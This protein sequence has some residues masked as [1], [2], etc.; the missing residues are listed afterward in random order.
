MGS[1]PTPTRTSRRIEPDHDAMISFPIFESLHVSSYGLFPGVSK[2]Q[3]GLHIRFQPG[4]TLVLGSNG[5]G[6][7]TL[8][9]II[10][11]LLTG[12]YDITALS[13]RTDLG[14]AKLVPTKLRPKLLGT[15]AQRVADGAQDSKARLTLSLGSRLVEIE[16][17]LSNFALTQFVIDGEEQDLH[18]I[19]SYQTQIARLAGVWSFGDWLLMLHHMVFYFENR[20]DLVWDP[21][22]QRQILRFLF[23]PPATAKQWTEEERS[24]L[25]LDSD[26]RNLSATVHR[27]E[28]EL[29]DNEA[30]LESAPEIR[31]ELNTLKGLQEIDWSRRSR[32]DDELVELNEMRESARLMLMRLEHRREASFREFERAHLMA[33]EA[34]LP[35]TSDSARYILSQLMTDQDCLACGRHVP[36][37]ASSFEKRI[38]SNKC[39]VCGQPLIE[40]GETEHVTAPELADRRVEIRLAELAELDKKV[41][42]SRGERD[43][44]ETQYTSNVEELAEL[45]HDIAKRSARIDSLA[46]SLPPE[47][48]DLHAHRA[49][50][51]IM[52][53]RVE[54][55]KQRLKSKRSA[56][57]DFVKTVTATVVSHSSAI[58]TAFEDYAHGFLLESCE[59][60]WSPQKARV[61]QSGL[62]IEFPAFQLDMSGATFPS[63]VQ[64][65]DPDQVSESQREFID[66]AFRMSLMSV[67]GVTGVGSLV[68]DAPESSLDAVFVKRA[69]QVLSRFADPRGGN[70][71]VVTSN[72]TEGQLIPSLLEQCSTPKTHADRLIDLFDIAEPTAA[73]R[74]NRDEYTQVKIELFAHLF[75]GVD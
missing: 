63:L 55:Q 66:L 48:S 9:T 64:R 10:N 12:P 38:D 13:S 25:K 54:I 28:Q 40:K 57:R 6:K 19:K 15:L 56:F 2:K 26:T 60:A 71:L 41:E 21:S 18:E 65:K 3:P 59:L 51:A 39:L 53:G 37:V 67:A 69:A 35:S 5:L 24:I 61:G 23:L 14:T 36:E 8:V 1:R 49:E 62:Q 47:E 45:D 75:Q 73:V 29:A 16:R 27:Q 22:A 33:I 20:R 17:R 52:R 70:R 74:E 7:T 11:R 72:L 4:L 50:L 43:K 44:R 42:F 46:R 68:I 30:K 58:K 34:R 31:E 32:L